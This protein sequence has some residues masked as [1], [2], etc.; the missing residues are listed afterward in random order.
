MRGHSEGSSPI[1]ADVLGNVGLVYDL[2]Y[3]PEETTLLKQA[4]EAGCRTLGGLAM[5]VAQA[6]EQ[7]RLFTGEEAPVPVM[8]RAARST[9]DEEN[10]EGNSQ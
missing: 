6:A 7:F 4:R 9:D 5:L 2:I 10:G 1:A 8:A 3:N